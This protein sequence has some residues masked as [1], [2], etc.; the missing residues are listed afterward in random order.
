MEALATLT[1]LAP[2][3]F[4]QS[5]GLEPAD[6][7]IERTLIHLQALLIE[8]LSKRVTVMLGTQETE[9]RNGQAPAPQLEP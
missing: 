3:A 1:F 2:L 9:Y 5:L 8:C 7:R 4:Q 6:E